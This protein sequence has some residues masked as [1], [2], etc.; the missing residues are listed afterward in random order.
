MWKI[1]HFEIAHYLNT[2]YFEKNSPHIN[3][4]YGAVKIV[5]LWDDKERGKADAN[6]KRIAA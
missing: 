3:L 2:W 4:V 1:G 5:L 6:G